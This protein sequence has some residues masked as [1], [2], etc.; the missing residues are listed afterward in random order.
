MSEAQ[1]FLD[2]IQNFDLWL[3]KADGLFTAALELTKSSNALRQ[4]LSSVADTHEGHE[5]R[6]QN[7][8]HLNISA[9]LLYG[10]ALETLFKGILLKHKPDSIELEMTMNGSGEIGSAKVNKLGV[11]MN[12]GHDLVI[13]ANEIGLFKLIENPKQ[14]KK[15]LNYLSECVKWRA[16]YPVPQES[17]KNRR[18]TGEEA[19]NFMVNSIL[20][21]FDP[22]YSKSLEIAD[23]GIPE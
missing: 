7:S 5:E 8:L 3:F 17:K 19:T 12:K 9:S 20:I 23:N 4:E 22:I 2:S 11:Q 21:H 6:W 10:Y 13:L 16:R 14:A 1:G 18:L 15:T